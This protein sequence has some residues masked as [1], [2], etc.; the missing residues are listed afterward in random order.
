MR[1]RQMLLALLLAI[2]VPTHVAMAQDNPKALLKKGNK[3]FAA[4]DY[5][6]AFDAFKEAYDK[7]PDAV[8]LRSMAFCQ[9]KLYRHEKARE[10]LGEYLKKYPKAPDFK[11]LKQLQDGLEVVIQTKV[12]IESTPSGAEVYIDAEAAGKVGTTPVDLTIEPGKHLVILKAEGY[13]TTTESLQIQPKESKTVKAVLEVPIKVSSTPAGA[14]VHFGSASS[15]TLG[16]TPIETG[17]KPGKQKVYLKKEGYKTYEVELDVQPGKT[18]T[19]DPQLQLGFR[20][21]SVPSGATVELDGK[22]VEGVTPLDLAV[23]GGAH[24]VVIKLAGYK[25]S[26]HKIDVQPGV[27]ADINAD[28]VGGG[29]L[30]MRTD[31]QGAEVKVGAVDVGATPIDQKAVP[32]GSQT[33]QVS[34]PDRRPWSSA[35]A[36]SDTEVVNADVK[37]GRSAWPVWVAGG[38][39]VAGIV[40]GSVGAVVARGRTDENEEVEGVGC[41]NKETGEPGDCSY[42]MH[43]MSTAGF[44]TAGVAAAAGLAYYLFFVRSKV[45]ITRTPAGQATAK[46]PRPAM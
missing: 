8:F 24:T 28:L 7:K 33:V 45:T 6:A 46:R 10:F 32:S 26:S 19:V 31:V 4:G 3:L 30:T 9:L 20:V 41:V 27:S 42:G 5:Q 39:T 44:I 21:A 2:V 37:L 13:F 17:I 11:K 1:T 23:P 22:P 14:S 25:D 35:V 40:M 36:F 12:R 34:H 18:I 29:M 38:L 15:A 43:H 16:N